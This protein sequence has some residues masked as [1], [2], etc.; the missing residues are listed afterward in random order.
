MTRHLVL[1]PHLDDAV[2]SCGGRIARDAG[3]GVDVEI[4]TVFAGDEP[5]D[6]ASPLVD[7]VFAL[8]DLPPGR[9]MASRRDEDRSA[10]ARLGATPSWW[11]EL[12][13][14]HR[15][16]PGTGAALYADLPSLFGPVSPAEEPLVA[17]LAAR[18]AKLPAAD[19]VLAPLGVGGHVDHR[20]LRA[21]AERALGDRIA[22]YEEFPYILWKLFA[23]ARARGPRRGW[24]AESMPLSATAVA[25]RIEAIGCY[26]SQVKPLFRDPARLARMVRRHV[27]RAGGERLW[28]RTGLTTE[29]ER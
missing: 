28:R 24:T 17:D 29:T 25:A 1:S 22:Y 9:V 21:A 6:S 18:L 26:A 14:I 16:D 27:R 19:R 15:R 12:E 3:A 20:L 4:L 2:L 7:R 8:W 5:P 11:G 23:L 10:C 13:A